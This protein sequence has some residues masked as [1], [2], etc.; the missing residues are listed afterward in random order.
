[1]RISTNSGVVHAMR[2]T[3]LQPQTRLI[4]S[5]TQ[6]ATHRNIAGI[7]PVVCD[8]I[9]KLANLQKLVDAGTY[10]SNPRGSRDA[11]EPAAR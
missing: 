8:G 2:L 10:T 7:V 3:S 5:T 4:P 9:L 6:P 11:V 1:M